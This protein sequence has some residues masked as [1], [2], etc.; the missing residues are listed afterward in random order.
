MG[1][2]SLKA[3]YIKELVRA[4]LDGIA[5][6]RHEMGGAA[7]SPAPEAVLWTPAAVG[8]ALGVL[9]TRLIGNRKSVS[10]L[11]MGGLVGSVVGFGAGFAWASRGYS[12]CAARRAIRFVNAAR[13]AH[14]LETHPIDYA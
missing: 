8:A 4:G 7:F 3:A 12:G 2:H 9:S 14:W 5:A 13:D 11:G 1:P 10:H 6:A